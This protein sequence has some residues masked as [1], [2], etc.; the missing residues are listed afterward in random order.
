MEIRRIVTGEDAAGNSVVTYSEKVEPIPTPTGRKFHRIWGMDATPTLPN[1]GQP[2]FQHTAMPPPEGGFRVSVLEFP[3]LEEE[4]PYDS[5][6]QS[7][8]SGWRRTFQD[9]TTG[10]HATD[11]VDVVV[12]LEG[13]MEMEVAGG[14][15]QTLTPG[16]IVVQIGAKHAWKNRS[17][18]PCTMA[19]I[20]LAAD[21]AGGA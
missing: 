15:T 1:D 6:A 18:K 16:S 20:V 17:G 19:V 7:E 2:S 3:P 21:R 10:M 8:F 13:E 4:I 5:Q 14:P 12:V 11:T 9:H